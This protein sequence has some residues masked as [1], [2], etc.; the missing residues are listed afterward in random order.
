[1]KKIGLIVFILTLILGAA[2][3]N[4]LTFGSSDFRL[5]RFSINRQVEGS[6]N[7][8]KESRDVSGF[9]SI[10]V[11]GV[12]E[13][14]FTAQTEYSVEVEADDNIVPIIHT[15]VDGGVLRIS[16]RDG[17]SK[18]SRLLVRVSAP[19]LKGVRSS[20]VANVKITNIKNIRFSAK[21]SGASK[22]SVAG[23]TLEMDVDSSGASAVD[24]AN[25]SAE[26]VDIDSSGAAQIYVNAAK[27]LRVDASGESR[28]FYSGS[29][30]DIKKRTSGGASVSQH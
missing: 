2:V 11:S 16:Q 3:A 23:E 18:Y 15:E 24:A 19:D 27:S 6:G 10:S 9:N 8:V 13:V 21:T 14:E 17:I 1:M 5:I 28:I 29:P 30:T 25:L 22:I 7:V 20:G 12:I 26:N 4:L